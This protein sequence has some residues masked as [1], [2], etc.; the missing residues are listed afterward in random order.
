MRIIDDGLANENNIRKPVLQGCAKNN[1]KFA[2]DPG[3]L[4]SQNKVG[5]KARS[6]NRDLQR[7]LRFVGISFSAS[8]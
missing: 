7:I 4:Q 5:K 6:A 1:R 8:K 2:A 3:I